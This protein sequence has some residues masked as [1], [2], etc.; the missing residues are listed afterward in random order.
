MKNLRLEVDSLLL[1]Q[2]VQNICNIPWNIDYILREIKN[3]LHPRF[4]ISHVFMVV[5]EGADS[6]D[7]LV[8][9]DANK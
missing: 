8:N 4:V 9:F 5:N 6:F 1:V 2:M 3:F 7:K